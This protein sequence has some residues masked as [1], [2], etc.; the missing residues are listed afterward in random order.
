[1][2]N[3]TKMIEEGKI[4]LKNQKKKNKID[5]I[6]NLTI[7]GKYLDLISYTEM[8]LKKFPKQERFALASF[9]KNTTYDGMEC[10]ILGFKLYDKTKKLE[11]L[12]LL[13]VKLKMLKVLIRVSYKAKY[14]SLQNYRA[15]SNKLFHVG[16]ILG[17]WINSCLKH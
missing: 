3:N 2:E 17:G 5:E 16:N 1:M 14:I 4:I 15:W 11:A 7:Y 8:I 13:D 6:E 12:N 10:I 9:I